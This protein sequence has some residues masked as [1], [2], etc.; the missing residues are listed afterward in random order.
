MFSCDSKT[1]P[2]PTPA[3]KKDERRGK[4]KVKVKLAPVP[5]TWSNKESITV[6]AMA[7]GKD[8]LVVAGPVDVGKKE[9]HL[10][11]A[12]PAGAQAAYEGKSDVFLQVINKEDGAKVFELKISDSP[13]FDGLS[14]TPGQIFMSGR[15]GVITCFAGD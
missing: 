10:A 7:A 9:G 5:K 2:A 13:S 1:I 6:K 11:F 14:I 15:N 12:N 4:K 3:E 8:R